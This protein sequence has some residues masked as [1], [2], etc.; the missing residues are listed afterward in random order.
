[1]M[2][3][4]CKTCLYWQ[5]EAAGR[6]ICRRHAPTIVSVRGLVDN[7]QPITKETDWCGE[8]A[9][10]IENPVTNDGAWRFVLC[11]KCKAMV[12]T[13]RCGQ[14]LHLCSGCTKEINALYEGIGEAKP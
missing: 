14:E 7:E 12:R 9:A 2:S 3:F 4:T 6:G 10:C 5:S 8:G 13:I 1:M 11:K